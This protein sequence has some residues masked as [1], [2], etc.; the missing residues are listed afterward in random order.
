MDSSVS[1]NSLEN[2]SSVSQDLDTSGSASNNDQFSYQDL[3]RGLAEAEERRRQSLESTS[4]A[5]T[6]NKYTCFEKPEPTM[7]SLTPKLITNNGRTSLETDLKFERA[8]SLPDER[9]IIHDN[10]SNQRIESLVQENKVLKC[11][12]ETCKLKVKSLQ[13][14]N[15]HLRQ[16]AVHIQ[17]KAEQEEEFISNTLLKKIQALKKEKESLAINYEQEEECLTNDL[18]RKLDQLRQEKVQLEHTLEQEQ[19]CLVN[20]LMRKIEKLETETT[21]KQVSLETLRREKVELENTL[22]QEQE[23]LV[24][25]LWKRMDHLEKEKRSLQ[26]RLDKPVSEPQSPRSVTDFNY[27]GGTA[28]N[29]ANNIRSLKK[30]CARL[31][32]QLISGKEEHERKMAEYAREEKEI[33]DENLRLQRRL[34]MEMERR[35]ALCRQLSESESSIEME[36]ERAYNELSF[37]APGTSSAS[38]IGSLTSGAVACHRTR[39]VSSELSGTTNEAANI[40]PLSSSLNY[41]ERELQPSEFMASSLIHGHNAGVVGFNQTA[42]VARL[43]HV[44]PSPSPSPPLPQTTYFTQP[45]YPKDGNFGATSVHKQPT[46]FSRPAK[47]VQKSV[48]MLGQPVPI[49]SN[50]T[51][52]PKNVG[53]ANLHGEALKHNS[54]ETMMETNDNG[55]YKSPKQERKYSNTKS[56]AVIRTSSP[57]LSPLN[58]GSNSSKEVKDNKAKHE[59]QL[60]K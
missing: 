15:K 50:V 37:H 46:T 57:N 9:A 49:S 60:G 54:S 44:A 47:S 20:K 12:L 35:E 32:Q 6:F 53:S 45:F 56:E 39:S 24:N 43:H 18:S 34:Q 17:A 11:E 7:S 52:A 22:E 29:L 19:E 14:E 26:V 51:P 58:L 23:A 59:L 36:E 40:I 30:E 5:N 21:N 10:H 25:K 55:I 2:T 48:S 16:D 41:A 33:K 1:S 4:G 28:A 8:I 3:P 38:S 27:G 13:E 31:K 42:A